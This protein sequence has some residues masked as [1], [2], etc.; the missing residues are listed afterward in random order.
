MHRTFGD[1]IKDKMI[2][3]HTTYTDLAAF[4]RCPAKIMLDFVSNRSIPTLEQQELLFSTLQF[5][6]T[7]QD[8]AND[9]IGAH[10]MPN[11]LPPDITRILR[12]HPYIITAIRQGVRAGITEQD[13]QNFI[14]GH[15]V[16][17]D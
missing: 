17:P 5:T 10:W 13:L 4:C 16:A 11:G 8:G 7:E 12:N 6:Q 3:Q 15:S 9:L 14:A 1:L 2:Q